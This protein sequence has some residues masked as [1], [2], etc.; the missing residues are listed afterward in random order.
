[1]FQGGNAPDQFSGIVEVFV[2]G[3]WGS[4]CADN[5]DQ[6]DADVFCQQIQYTS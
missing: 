1:M 6:V 3:R 2:N 5:W 4:V